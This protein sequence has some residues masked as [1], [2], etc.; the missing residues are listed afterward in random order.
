LRECEHRPYGDPPR[1]PDD[2][3]RRPRDPALAQSPASRPHSR[4]VTYD[5][6]D[7]LIRRL[8]MTV[9]RLNRRPDATVTL[10]VRNDSDRLLHRE[11]QVGRCTGGAALALV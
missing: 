5:R 9:T 7:V 10:T 6:G 8:Q 11:L 2:D 4:V 3:R 1:P